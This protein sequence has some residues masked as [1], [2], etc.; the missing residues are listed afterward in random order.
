MQLGLLTCAAVTLAA[1]ADTKSEATGDVPVPARANNAV[2]DATVWLRLSPV[3]T[4][5]IEF[6]VAL[7]AASI[8]G[9]VPSGIAR[10]KYGD[11]AG[12]GVGKTCC[13]FEGTLVHAPHIFKYVVNIPEVP[14]ESE[15]AKVTI[16]VVVGTPVG[17]ITVRAPEL[18]GFARY[19]SH[20]VAAPAVFAV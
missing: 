18:Y 20:C 17:A 5:P 6:G 10:G 2:G 13:V 14:L 7:T 11:A 8:F 4:Y 15:R 12:G 1:V 16:W 9:V 3:P 19:V